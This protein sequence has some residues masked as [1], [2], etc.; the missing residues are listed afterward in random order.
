VSALPPAGAVGA[1]A[2]PLALLQSLRYQG[3]RG[4]ALMS[5]RRRALQHV[6]V[7]TLIGDIAKSALVLRARND[8]LKVTEKLN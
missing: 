1:P 3:E 7:P 5:Q 8:Q 6:T 2:A 4:F